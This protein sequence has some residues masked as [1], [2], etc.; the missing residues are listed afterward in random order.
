VTADVAIVGGGIVGCA[1]AAF[2]AADGVRVTLVEQT[3]IAA[4]AS[5]RNSG[6]VQ[7]PFDEVLAGLYRQSVELYR[8][9]AAAMPDAFRLGDRPAGLL[10]VA[11]AAADAAAAAIVRAWAA[12]HPSVAAEVVAGPALTRLDSALADDLVACRLDIGYP[13]APASATLAYAALARQLGVEVVVGAAATMAVQGDAVTGLVVDGRHIAAGRVVVAAGPWTPSVI[14]GRAWDRW[15]P[16]ARSWGLVATVELARPPLHVLEELDIDIEPDEPDERDGAVPSADPDRGIGFSLVT[17]EGSS[18]LGSTFLPEPPPEALIDRLRARGARYVPE[19]ATA[20]V[21][22]TR[23]C[24]R[25]VSPDGRP[26]IGPV[27]GLRNA[28]VA[29]GH[30]PWGISTGPGSAR[31]VA[32]LVLGRSESGPPAL[33]PGRFRR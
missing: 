7:H 13:V 27:P 21:V 30:G 11:P 15:P 28:F 23:T 22:A 12:T 3:E 26:L 24:A 2:L 14:D 18:A 1:T 4:A 16:I 33:D 5:G 31:I 10:Y 19:I 8:D 17:A 29:A 25:P 9:L 20:E 32:D 6:V